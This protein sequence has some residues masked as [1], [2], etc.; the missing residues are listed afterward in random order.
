MSSK[1]ESTGVPPEFEPIVYALKRPL[2]VIENGE[3]RGAYIRTVTVLREPNMDDLIASSGLDPIPMLRVVIPRLT[4]LADA[5]VGKLRVIDVRGL[6]EVINPLF[7]A[8][9]DPTPAE[10]QPGTP[11]ASNA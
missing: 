2:Q 3:F 7:E 4:T 10:S 9:K 6:S 11:G 1:T 8:E 5:F